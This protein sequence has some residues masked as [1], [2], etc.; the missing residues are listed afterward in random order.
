MWTPS[1]STSP[2][3]TY[4]IAWVEQPHSGWIR[5][6][7]PGCSARR[8]LDVLGPDAGVNMA[9]AVPDVEPRVARRIVGQ[10]GLAGDERA[11]PHV[12]AEED[13]RVR[14]VLAPD[15]LDHLDRVGRRAA[16]VRLGLHLG[17]GVDV[18]DHH[19]AGMLGLPVAKL[20]GGDRLRQRAAGVGIGDQHG[21]L[22]RE[23]RGGLGHEVDAA[24]RDHVRVGGRRLAREAAASPP[25]GRPRPEP[26]AA[27]SCGRGSRRCAPRPAREPRLRAVR[28]PPATDRRAGWAGLPGDPASRCSNRPG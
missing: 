20:V 13:L 22:G 21:L 8:A 6:S 1:A 27:G 18:H 26:R 25:Y 12:G 7:A 5:N 9:L 4:S 23:N 11:Q 3:A 15:V 19:R 16:V 17:R 2:E 10:P 14:P 28:S 24:E